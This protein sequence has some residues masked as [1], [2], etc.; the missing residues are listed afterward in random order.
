MLRTRVATAAVAIPTLWLVIR[1]LPAPLFAGF[2]MA[3]TAAALLEYF[4][5]AMPSEQREREPGP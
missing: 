4:G 2:I 5:M 3:V 1:F